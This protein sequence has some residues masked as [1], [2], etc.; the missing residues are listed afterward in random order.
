VLHETVEQLQ[1]LPNMAL[2]MD[3]ITSD[4]NETLEAMR[5]VYDRY[6][7]L[8]L[9]DVEQAKEDLPGIKALAK[10]GSQALRDVDELLEHLN[11]DQNLTIEPYFTDLKREKHLIKKLYR[12]LTNEVD[13]EVAL[14]LNYRQILDDL[15]VLEAE[16]R[17]A[18]A[19]SRPPD[20]EHALNQVEV[21]LDLLKQQCRVPRKYI[22][23]SVDGS[24]V[25]SPTRRRNI[26][27]KI[28]NTVTTII[29]VVED[30][31][32]RQQQQQMLTANLRTEP[33]LEENYK[34]LHRKLSALNETAMKENVLSPRSGRTSEEPSL[35]TVNANEIEEMI[36]S[37]D[38]IK[39]SIADLLETSRDV[40]E[41]PVQ[42][43]FLLRA[44][45]E[46]RHRLE[47]VL[48]R[49]NEVEFEP[50]IVQTYGG[51]ISELINSLGV[52]NNVQPLFCTK[53]I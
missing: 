20:V 10:R 52:C 15:S 2:P 43:E 32:R 8:P 34:V 23:S 17:S 31:L 16:V 45:K 36:K 40:P 41:T 25:S 51:K 26:I 1:I 13:D 6:N 24:R 46:S 29:K 22:I 42:Y 35:P 48:S 30:A 37:A 7:S 49:I 12:E 14:R 4:L 19:S 38:G 33:E 9:K 3:G 47:H 21:E 18:A 39:T 44:S 5:R 11:A 27:V 50:F 28:T 53:R